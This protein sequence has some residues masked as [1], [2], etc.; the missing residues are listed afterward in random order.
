MNQFSEI[1]HKEN[2]IKLTFLI[3]SITTSIVILLTILDIIIGSSLGGDISTIPQSAIGKFDQFQD[4][5][6]LGL[7]N[8]D[9]LNLTVSVIMI[10]SFLALFVAHRRINNSFSILALLIFIIGTS[11]FI[12]NNAALPMFDLSQKYAGSNDNNQKLLL[13]AAGEA[14]IVKG[15]HGGFGAFPGF[16]LITLSEM[17]ISFVMLKSA[18][19]SKMTAYV[20]LSGTLLLIIYLILVTFVPSIKSVAMVIAAPGGLLTLAWMIMF[21]IKLFKLSKV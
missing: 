20:G 6:L 19:F 9:F 15:A 4:N 3:G 11:I 13:A 5:T 17:L 12:A 14:L 2:Q 10:P 1:D 21:T 16:V 7:Y 8:L 18:I